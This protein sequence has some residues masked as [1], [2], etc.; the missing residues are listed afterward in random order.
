MI[1]VR[2]FNEKKLKPPPRAPQWPLVNA[3]A[4]EIEIGAGE[5]R[6]AET[7]A[8]QNPQTHFIAIEHTAERFSKFKRRIDLKTFKN[9]TLIHADAVA[10]VTAYVKPHSIDRIWIMYPN[11]NPKNLAKRW[12]RMPFFSKL[13]EGLKRSGEVILA[14]NEENYMNEAMLFAADAWGLTLES[15]IKFKGDEAQAKARTLFEK[16]YL[17]RG[18]ICFE[19]RWRKN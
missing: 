2:K 19:T 14:T 1:L 8:Q 12:F 5:G 16:K 9:L 7:L 13:V 6:F 15:A 18:Q 4:V 10:W 17:E 3:K 11:P